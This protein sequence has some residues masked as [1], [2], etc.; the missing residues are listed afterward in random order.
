MQ[1]QNLSFQQLP[2]TIGGAR[3]HA[4]C[5]KPMPCILFF[6]N[7]RVSLRS[8]NLLHGII[9]ELRRK[10]I[11]M[12]L[13][14]YFLSLS[15]TGFNAFVRLS[16][17]LSRRSKINLIR[18]V[19][20]ALLRKDKE[21]AENIHHRTVPFLPTEPS[22]QSGYTDPSTGS[23]KRDRRMTGSMLPD[24]IVEKVNLVLPEAPHFKPQLHLLR[25]SPR[26]TFGN[27]RHARRQLCKCARM[28][29]HLEPTQK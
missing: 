3:L 10:R 8:G 7:F 24:L 19:C 21:Q 28:C 18:S 14:L 16:T 9:T 2:S 13:V 17:I 29:T 23:S 4:F 5:G 22:R 20:T 12:V 1:S 6:E 27:K 11:F 25:I 26:P 15:L